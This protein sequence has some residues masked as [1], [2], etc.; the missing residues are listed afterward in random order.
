MDE[1]T[2]VEYQGGRQGEEPGSDQQ[3]CP[4]KAFGQQ[5]QYDHK[6]Q[7]KDCRDRAKGGFCQGKVVRLSDQTRQD[8]GCVVQ[9]RAMIF[10]LIVPILT[11]L[12]QNAQ[13]ICID[14]FIVVHGPFFQAGET[15]QAGQHE[16]GSKNQEVFQ[17]EAQFTGLPWTSTSI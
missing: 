7:S 13:L 17:G 2:A 16:N 8:A 10:I 3:G 9:H 12:D 14:C 4:A 15:G 11:C 1:I 6:G 5:Q